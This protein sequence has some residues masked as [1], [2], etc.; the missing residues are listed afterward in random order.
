MAVGSD[1]KKWWAATAA[2]V[3]AVAVSGGAFFANAASSS[4]SSVVTID[5]VRIMD[6]RDGNDIGLAG[7]FVSATS[8][9][10]QVTGSIPTATG[11]Q[12]VVP[13]GATGVLLNVTAVLP[14]ANGFISVRPGD[15]TGAPT[16]SS[17]NF[18]AG[19]IVP[20]SVQ[21][22]LPTSGANA[23]KIDITYDAFGV[24]GPTTDILVD[25]VGYLQAAN[26]G[27]TAIDPVDQSL[28]VTANVPFSI[29][30][31]CPAGS[32]VISGGFSAEDIDALF[33]G[34]TSEPSGTTGWTLGGTKRSPSPR[35]VSASAELDHVPATPVTSRIDAASP[36]LARDGAVR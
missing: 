30:A 18:L 17:L 6:T 23:G 3:L 24:A 36:E 19:E 16:T 2:V 28:V 31:Q 4:P 32:S 8:Q 15:A 7:P 22:A 27:I 33:G 5:P 29:T 25:V 1:T 14:Q 10:L 11:T 21:V 12:V 26:P 13:A 9:K 20:N 35:S 34:I